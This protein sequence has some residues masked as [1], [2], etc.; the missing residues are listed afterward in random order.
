[1]YHASIIC[2]RNKLYFHLTSYKYGI[3]RLNDSVI[4]A[5]R[6]ESHSCKDRIINNFHVTIINSFYLKFWPFYLLMSLIPFFQSAERLFMALPYKIQRTLVTL[7]E[8]TS[9]R[10]SGIHTIALTHTLILRLCK[11]I[12]PL[13][14]SRSYRPYLKNKLDLS[15][16]SGPGITPAFLLRLKD[17][18]FR[19][20]GDI[21]QR[22]MEPEPFLSRLR[23]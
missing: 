14:E 3:E 11:N 20:Y 17:N 10:N 6:R 5:H 19:R 21:S 2:M 15:A 7:F 18:Y 16:S 12:I 1:L 22:R 4:H 23:L 8:R 9:I 13:L